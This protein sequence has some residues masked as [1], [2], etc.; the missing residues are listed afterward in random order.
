M[1]PVNT[2]AGSAT[3]HTAIMA[4]SLNLPAV[5]ATRDLLTN[6]PRLHWSWHADRL[7]R[8][9]DIRQKATDDA[10]ARVYVPRVWRNA[11]TSRSKLMLN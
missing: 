8:E 11:L 7:P 9:G 2:E 4:R 10:A 1:P 6:R 5:V 3:S